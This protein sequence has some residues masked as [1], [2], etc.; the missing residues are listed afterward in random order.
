[1]FSRT[2]IRFGATL[3]RIF[4]IPLNY[5]QRVMIS[6]LTPL[7]NSCEFH[8]AVAVHYRYCLR[9]HITQALLSTQNEEG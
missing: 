3:S 4:R 2:C 8:K 6:I 5:Q 1:M 9:K 7:K